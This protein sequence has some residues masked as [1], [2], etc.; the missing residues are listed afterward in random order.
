MLLS[1]RI[2][3]PAAGRGQVERVATSC[4]ILMK[5]SSHEGRTFF[6]VSCSRVVS[7]SGSLKGSIEPV[8]GVAEARNDK[9]APVQLGAE[10]GGVE[11]DVGVLGCD[12]FY[13][14]HGGDGVEA[15]DPGRP[16]LL[17]L[18]DGR[19]QAPAGREHGIEDE[20][21]GLLEGAGAGGGA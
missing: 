21:P 11:V 6:R 19:G 3:G 10:G 8:A 12:A 4:E 2:A 16:L 15:G 1:R 17:E 14:G 18:V 9:R 13:A 7:T 20:H 5:Y